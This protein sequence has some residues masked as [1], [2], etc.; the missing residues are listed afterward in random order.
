VNAEGASHFKAVTAGKGD[1]AW[2]FEEVRVTPLDRIHGYSY[3]Y[4]FTFDPKQGSISRVE[5]EFTQSYGKGGRSLGRAELVAAEKRDA[6]WIA[7][8]SAESDLYFAAKA[9]YLAL[10]QRAE[11][12]P[13]DEKTR[14]ADASA[15][16]LARIAQRPFKF[17]DLSGSLLLAEAKEDLTRARDASTLPVIRDL[18]DAQ[19]KQ[20]GRTVSSS[21]KSAIRRARVVGQPAAE[22]D[23]K[24]LEGKTRSLKDY[25]GKVVVLDFW[26]RGCGWCIRAMPQVN[27]LAEDFKDQPVAVLGMN[28]DAEE[29]DARFVVEAMNLKYPV[30]KVEEGLPQEYS[31]QGY[32]TLVLIGPDGIVRDL[33][34][35]YSPTLREEVGRAIRE[36]LPSK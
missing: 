30:L 28:I 31:I 26:Y 34:V 35:G 24:D 19:L 7:K 27:Q 25:R 29:R 6:D 21:R 17:S 20:H 18:I 22:W 8:L 15:R 1:G 16:A 3:K 4:R 9:A 13:I 36:L 14:E 12:E 2:V 10:A 11:K 33:H 23:L 5:D 32:P